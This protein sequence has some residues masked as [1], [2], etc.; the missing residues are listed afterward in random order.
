L[1]SHEPVCLAGAAFTNFL[2]VVA[3]SGVRRLLDPN[4]PITTVG[5]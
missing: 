1:S 3:R 5:L 4:L 2:T